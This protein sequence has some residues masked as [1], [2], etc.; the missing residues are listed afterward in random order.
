MGLYDNVYQKS[1]YKF[2]K[3]CKRFFESVIKNL[4]GNSGCLKIVDSNGIIRGV[5]L[6]LISDTHLIPLYVGI[7]YTYPDVKHLYINMILKSIEIAE[8][9]KKKV[10]VWGQTSY[11]A[12]ISSGAVLERVYLGFN[13]DSYLYKIMIKVFMNKFY[14]SY[15][16][17]NKY[18]YKNDILQHIYAFMEKQNIEVIKYE[19][20]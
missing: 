16:L 7:D 4:K 14:H 15:K 5:A 13:S 18:A 6:V 8:R 3:L 1:D 20:D 11:Y 9:L 12:K 2:E 17:E 10:I 19:D